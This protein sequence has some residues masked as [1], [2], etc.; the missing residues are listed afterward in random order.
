MIEINRCKLHLFY[1]SPRNIF[2][3]YPERNSLEFTNLCTLRIPTNDFDKQLC[4]TS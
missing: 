4:N 1:C 3:Y 2:G